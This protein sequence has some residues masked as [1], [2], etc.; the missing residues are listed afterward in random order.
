[1]KTL[2]T[3]AVF[4]AAVFSLPVFATSNCP[5]SVPP[6]TKPNK[7]FAYFPLVDDATF[8]AY[9]TLVSPAKKFDINDLD[10][11][12][13]TVAQLEQAIT[14][15]MVDHYCEFNVDVQATTTNPDGF[16]S[17]PPRR[18]IVAV[19][20]DDHPSLYGEALEV[21]FNASNPIDYA[22]EWGQ[23]YKDVAGGIGGALYGANSTLQRWANSLGGTA[24]HE[25]GH[26]YGLTHGMGAT[27][28]SGEPPIG[29]SLMP[30]GGSVTSE[31]RA[32]YRH[33]NDTSYSVLA[34]NVGL[35]V[36]TVHNW[37]FK[38]PNATAANKLQMEILSTK[39]LLTLSW[40]YTGS[41]SP[42][43]SP[44]VSGPVGTVNFKGTLYNRFIVTWSTP[45]PAWGGA[46]GTVAGGGGFHIGAEFTGVNFN[47]PEVVIVRSVTLY[48]GANPLTLHPRMVG[49]DTGS[50]DV[51]NGI[52]NLALFAPGDMDPGNQII[53]RNIQV[54]EL[55]RLT[56]LESMMSDGRPQSWDGLAITPWRTSRCQDQQIFAGSEGRDTATC[57]IAR[58]AQGR[59]I[60]IDHSRCDAPTGEQGAKDAWNAGDEVNLDPCAQAYSL[61]LFPATAV[62]VIAT[63]VE[64]NATYFDPRIGGY[65]RGNL[66]SKLFYQFGGH[67]PDLNNNGIDDYID[68]Y[69]GTSRDDNHDGV[70][71]EVQR[72]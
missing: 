53:L 34:A 44:T 2:N 62:Y 13:G 46:P 18:N 26:I 5:L 11:A 32:N 14:D 12:V 24:S 4:V 51:I 16:I 30:A 8:P 50:M 3:L 15:V 66:E 35:A 61:D 65:V 43:T 58:L 67:H 6:D 31:D 21:N 23:S 64:V 40:W 60:F 63:V 48:N 42:W 33:F 70:P 41:T 22:R 56:S 71:D 69:T 36:Q 57:Q 27:I 54:F 49:Y 29:K 28:L 20:S 38:N 37:D 17:P 52:Y 72:P 55:P 7:L 59:H 1:M 25:A 10:P 39:G 9:D 68:I 47:V 19:G 45:N